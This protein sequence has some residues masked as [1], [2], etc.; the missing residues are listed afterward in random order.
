METPG[1]WL[2]E[3]ANENS[4]HSFYGIDIY[5]GE[6]TIKNRKC[7]KPQP[8]RPDKKNTLTNSVLWHKN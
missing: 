2:I 8:T 4:E 7:K 5:M 1:R 6:K 3:Y